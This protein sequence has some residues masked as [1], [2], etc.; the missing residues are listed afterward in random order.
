M[1]QQ[2]PSPASERM[3]RGC[4]VPGSGMRPPCTCWLLIF[5]GILRSWDGADSGGTWKMSWVSYN[6]LVRVCQGEYKLRARDPWRFRLQCG[7][8]IRDW[9]EDDGI[10]CP[11]PS[12][13]SLVCAEALADD[14]IWLY[15]S[16]CQA[17][18]MLTD[19]MPLSENNN[20]PCENNARDIIG[21]NPWKN[22]SFQGFG[23][24]YF[25]TVKGRV[26]SWLISTLTQGFMQFWRCH[27]V[28][29]FRMTRGNFIMH[30]YV[31]EP[32]R[33][34]IRTGENSNMCIG[35]RG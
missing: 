23:N 12:V 7:F 6:E 21:Y 8:G 13:S 28:L 30:D 16:K 5:L 20:K 33:T 32:H 22:Q 27:Q 26:S 35:V 34:A 2:R 4:N 3:C 9:P 29:C 1:H 25:G 18:V 15:I 11:L 17:P 24:I 19:R 10:W 14:I 31:L